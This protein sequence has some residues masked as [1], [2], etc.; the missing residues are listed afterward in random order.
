MKY[1]MGALGVVIS[2]PVANIPFG[3]L[4]RFKG[5]HIDA[6][7]FQRPPEPLDHPIINPAT[8]TVHGDF[9]SSRL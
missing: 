8:F 7:I 9:Y 6:F 1:V 5:A 3:L 2:H 4:A